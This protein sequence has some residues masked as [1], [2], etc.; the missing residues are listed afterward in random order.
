MCDS[1]FF[2]ACYVCAVSSAFTCAD[3]YALGF[4][5]RRRVVSAFC[6]LTETAALDC[7]H[8]ALAGEGH[9]MTAIRL[10]SS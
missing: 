8:H 6:H 3:T 10:R 2:L 9:C 4:T 7:A 5:A 1:T